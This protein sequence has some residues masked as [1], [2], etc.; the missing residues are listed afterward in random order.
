MNQAI[1]PDAQRERTLRDLK[2]GES[3]YTVPW[4]VQAD[5]GRLLWISTSFGQHKAPGG[6]VQMLV[7]RTDFGWCVE[8]PEKEKYRPRR[9]DGEALEPVYRFTVRSYS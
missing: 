6:T 1:L 4:A 3:T 7:T 5:P 9:L 8:V 2:P